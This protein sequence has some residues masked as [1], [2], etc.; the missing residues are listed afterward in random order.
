MYAWLAGWL[1]ADR[2]RALIPETAGLEVDVHPLPN[3]HAVNVVLQGFLGRGVAANDLLDPQAKGL[4][5]RLRARVVEV[6]TDLLEDIEGVDVV[7]GDGGDGGDGHP[8]VRPSAG[9]QTG[10]A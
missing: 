9:P 7:G 3:L 5:E 2:V 6:P 10:H 8:A 1:T 4:G